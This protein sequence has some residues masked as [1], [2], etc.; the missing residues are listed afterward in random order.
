MSAM[1]E[2]A[3]RQVVRELGPLAA[4]QQLIA[5]NDALIRSPELDNGREITARRTAIHTG[6][7]ADWAASQ[8][9]RFRYERPFAL[10]A[11]GGTGRAEMT[12]CSDTDFALLFDEAIEGNSFLQA[13]HEQTVH[14]NRF[15]KTYGFRIWPQPYNLDHMPA[16]EG[17]QLNSF[18][19]MRPVYDPQ[20]LA[21][22]FRDRIRATFDP[23]QHFLHVSSSWGGACCVPTAAGSER[24]DR[25]DIKTAGLRTFLAGVWT[26][27]GPQFRHS[28]DVYRGLEDTRD[29]DAYFFLLRIR[30]WIHLR[31]GTYRPGNVDGTHD[32]DVLGFED[33]ESFGELLGPGADA[34][35]RF[36][37]ANQVRARL[38]AARRR[39]ERFAR[40]VLGRELQQGHKTY[41]GSTIIHGIGGLRHD[42]AETYATPQDRSS[43]AMSLL[44]A[45]QRYGVGIDPAELEGVYRNA[46][47]WL[48]RVPELSG[49]FYETRGSLADSL[50]F[51]SQIDGAM[52]RLFPGYNKFESSLD[53]RVLEERVSLRGAWL[54]EKLRAFEHCLQL[55]WKKRSQERQK[56]W[57]PLKASLADMV[58]AESSLLDANH[59]AAVK[60]ALVVKRLPKTAEDEAVR[61]DERL[62]LHERF[63]SGF[64]DVAIDEYFAPYATEGGFT[65]STV[66]V[67][68]FLVA[69]RKAL[70]EYSKLGRNDEEVV[71]NFVQLCGDVGQLRSLF[72]FTCADRLM[73]MPIAEPV[74]GS[75]GGNGNGGSGNGGSGSGDSDAATVRKRR[76]WWLAENNA[77]RWFNTRELYIKALAHFVPSIT[78]DANK[79]LNAAGYGSREREILGDFGRDYFSGLYVRHTNQFASH[80]LR[81]VDEP[82]AGPK[83]EL[84][85][86]RDCI[87]L[88]VAARDFRGLAACIAG[89][90]H[91]HH[92]SLSQAHLFSA[93]KY[94]LALDFFHLAADQPLPRDLASVVRDA[95]QRH[96]HISEIDA[97]SLPTLQ[98]TTRLQAGP[99]NGCC[100]RHE[101]THPTSGLLYAITCK[102]YHQ[103]GGSIHGLSAYTSKGNSYVTVHLTLPADLP[104]HEAQFLVQQY[105]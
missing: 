4:Y 22:H 46:G 31:R 30:A 104:L 17:M 23:F 6:L 13:L 96:S 20:D 83:V 84:V 65:E 70:K 29:L 44:I 2:Y 67:A 12:P 92:V 59:L 98:G 99:G 42:A 62:E 58:V 97:A 43:A 93:N 68:E 19:D 39:V 90:L 76:A 63:A 53:E 64:S 79:T 72:V 5:A 33:F 94:G 50:E 69:N 60:L 16:L 55:G 54:R 102:V 35:T 95:V 27:G 88:G 28:H 3:V 7:A 85:R 38:L 26:L 77:V 36:E 71:G 82:E 86:D 25:F 10:V 61:A 8:R 73:G 78:L 89:A 80:L 11:L 56:N 47:D 51:L 57:D 75:G 34:R 45:A 37:F 66:R 103:L 49:L 14:G 40:G 100:L 1:Y 48:L 81:L 18:L 21:R 74:S 87:L 32:E 101:T 91:R 52:E 41:P 24:L 9:E 15:E 105:F